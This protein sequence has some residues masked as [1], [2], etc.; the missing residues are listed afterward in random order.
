M[1]ETTFKQILNCSPDAVYNLCFSPTTVLSSYGGQTLDVKCTFKAWVEAIGA[2][3]PRMFAEFV[4]VSDGARNLMGYETSK[5]MKVAKV[6]LSVNNIDNEKKMEIIEL[7]SVQPPEIYLDSQKTNE[8]P[9]IPGIKLDFEIKADV[10][11]VKYARR[12]IPL[13]MQKHVNDRLLKMLQ[14][15]I[16]EKAPKSTKWISPM[17]IVP[18]SNGDASALSSI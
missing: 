1:W 6:G 3:K 4:V 18:K 13:S 7:S 15:G 2:D 16:L 5:G 9:K 17:H 11:P 10:L 14:L 8:F 12:N